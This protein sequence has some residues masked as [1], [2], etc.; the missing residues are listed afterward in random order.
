MSINRD[1]L[2]KSSVPCS[3]TQLYKKK[4]EG[5]MISTPI[6]KELPNTL[7]VVKSSVQNIAYNKLS[8]MF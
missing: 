1:G 3:T 4:K 8:V 2:N 7:T 6:W 5:T